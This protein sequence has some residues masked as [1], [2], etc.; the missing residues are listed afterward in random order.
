[1]S[2][3]I[4]L[5]NERGVSEL[6]WLHS[7]FSFSFAE[8]HNH[9]RMGFG[10][11]RVINDDIIKAGT[12]FGMHPHR[13]MEIITIV[14]K[15]AL[16]HKDSE[17]NHGI[18]HA[19]EIQY[20]SAGTGV[21]HSEHATQESDTELFQIWIYPNRFGYKPCYEQRDFRFLVDKKGWHTL[22]S[23]DG[24]DHSIR[25]RQDATIRIA[26]LREGE[27]LTLPSLCPGCGFLLLVMSG[28]LSLN[29]II[30]NLRDEIQITDNS[31]DVVNAIEDSEILLFEVPK[32]Q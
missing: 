28:K 23:G 20:M 5:S 27:A 12:G 31:E 30:L 22:V 24:I 29:E 3:L 4:H 32:Y 15:G 19:G 2:K 16:E 13:D 8:Y 26:R 18:I 14:T 7:R 9:D 11:L 25:I 6:G 21:Y 10:A 1:M 17:G